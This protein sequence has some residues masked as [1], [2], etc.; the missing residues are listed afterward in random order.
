MAHHNFF[1]QIEPVL[2]YSPLAPIR[3]ARH[4]GRDCM[5]GSGHEIGRVTPEEIFGSTFDAL[6]Y[7][8][9]HDAAYTAPVTDPLVAADVNEPPWDRRV[10]RPAQFSHVWG[11]RPIHCPHTG[12]SDPPSPPPP[13]QRSWIDPPQART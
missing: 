1:L 11:T 10:P 13:R 7:R 4:Y 12:T 5:R 3:C 6:V 8:R 9:Y 2:A